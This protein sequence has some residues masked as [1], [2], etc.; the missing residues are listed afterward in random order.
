MTRRRIFWAVALAVWTAMLFVPNPSLS[1]VGMTDPPR[2]VK[3]WFAKA[4]HVL[5]YAGL[6][7]SAGT[8]QIPARFRWSILYV[9]MVH[10]TVTEFVQLFIPGRLGS[11][12]D[13]GFDHI[14][15]LLGLL[16][17]WKSWTST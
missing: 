1:T 3:Y 14:G 8:L 17:G 9:L 10:A 15:V 12:E 2:D 6:A 4:L 11:L 7:A 5:A 16:A 13:V